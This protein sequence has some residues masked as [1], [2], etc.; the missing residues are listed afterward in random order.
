M[1][2]VDVYALLF[3]YPLYF[4]EKILGYEGVSSSA[5]KETMSGHYYNKYLPL[6]KISGSGPLN[7]KYVT[8]LQT[9][10]VGETDTLANVIM[11]I[12]E[13]DILAITG[14]EGESSDHQVM[15]LSGDGN[16]ISSN[17]E[18]EEQRQMI[19]N[20][21]EKNGSGSFPMDLP[22]ESGMVITYS[23]SKIN[24]WIYIAYTG[25]DRI[26]L[27]LGRIR[28]IAVT[29]SVIGIGLGILLSF[30][31][32]GTS[33][34]PWAL[35]MDEMKRLFDKPMNH[36][37]SGNEYLI[38]RDAMRNIQAERERMQRDMDKGN[39]Y[40]R[41]YMLRNLCLGELP[42]EYIM[43]WKSLFPYRYYSV[44]LADLDGK[45]HL[46]PRIERIL[47]RLAGT[48]SN[49]CV[50]YALEDEKSRLCIVLNTDSREAVTPAG[51]IRRL[52]VIL[53][54]H[55]AMPLFAGVGGVRESMGEIQTSF[56]EARESLEYCFLKGK[57]SVVCFAEIEKQIFHTL[58]LPVYDDNPLLNAVKTGDIKNCTKLLDRYFR[59]LPDSSGT[60]TVQYMYCL[61]Y[62]LISVIL[63][64]CNEMQV[65]FREVFRQTPDRILDIGRYR[66][67]RQ[68]IDDIYHVYIVMCD[69]IQQNN[70]PRNNALKENIS[71]YL[72]NNYANMDM[73]LEQ[74]AGTFRYSSSYLSR[75]I[76]KEFGIG[77]GELLN[78][79][80]LGHA[81]KLLAAEL[82]PI[83]EI[84]E[85]VGY[86]NINSFNRAFKREE[87]IT[88]SQYRS[89]SLE[90]NQKE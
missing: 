48:R 88:P 40:A 65:D 77:F 28:D 49:H 9:I 5:V 37:E 27:Q 55:F 68:M 71:A 25:M 86:M 2:V 4:F 58:R 29:I 82:R 39:S 64:A 66:N 44:I 42:S 23:G 18:E 57:E 83:N 22:E 78:R 11:F 73:S 13:K 7:G 56:Q 69:Y 72:D 75:F 45:S 38:A 80:R 46:F 76:K 43:E 90:Q 32:A 17:S 3:V 35:L 89:L 67:T 19:F 79:I 74:I 24:D 62:N 30:L 20:R 41:K 53:S 87:G 54:K 52:A 14:K 12:D 47:N 33:Y 8:Y 10:P 61:F 16:V 70:K 34:K 84:S 6:K 85:M 51:Q 60:V 26:I 50:L 31:M 36:T 21:I 15:I 81:K 63:K 59:D 1:L